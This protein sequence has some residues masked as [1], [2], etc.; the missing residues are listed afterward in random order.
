LQ[1]L[2]NQVEDLTLELRKSV[3][4]TFEERMS[5]AHRAIL[6]GD[7]VAEQKVAPLRDQIASLEKRVAKLED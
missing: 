1:A 4:K 3:N 5:G 7:K 6:E 2:K